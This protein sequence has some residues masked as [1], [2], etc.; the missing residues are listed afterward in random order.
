M[1]EKKKR[2]PSVAPGMMGHDPL[3]KKATS[4]DRKK[5]DFTRVT[6]LYIDRTPGD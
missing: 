6:R 5:G 4:A 2:R 1:S 3:E